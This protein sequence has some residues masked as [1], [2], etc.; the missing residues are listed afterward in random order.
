MR[1]EKTCTEA[2]VTESKGK[3]VVLRPILMVAMCPPVP[4]FGQ[5]VEG[6][7]EGRYVE[8]L[9][10]SG[11]RRGE[12]GAMAVAV[13][14]LFMH[15]EAGI[16]GSSIGQGWVLGGGVARGEGPAPTDGRCPGR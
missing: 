8:R 5:V 11:E 6:G 12:R 4:R 2:A 15:M 14:D 16:G 13:A 1:R 7:K 9:E 3:A 10:V